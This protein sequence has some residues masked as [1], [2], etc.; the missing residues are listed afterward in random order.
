M[1]IMATTDNPAPEAGLGD[2]EDADKVGQNKAQRRIAGASGFLMFAVLLSRLLG[3]VREHVISTRFG[4]GVDTDIYTAAFTVPDLIFF[5][6]A[7]GGLSTAIIPTFTQYMNEGRKKEAWRIFKVVSLYTT[8][9]VGVLILIGEVFANTLIRHTNPGFTDEEVLRCVGL[10]RILLPAQICFFLG[11]LMMGVLQTRNN[12]RGQAYGPIIYNLGIIFGGV[13]LTHFMPKGGEIAGLCWGAV[14]GALLGNLALQWWF[15]KRMGGYWAPE[16]LREM[17]RD[18]GVKE[19]ALQ[20]WRM[21]LPI[22]LGVALPQVSALM[23][24]YYASYLDKGTMSALNRANQL[25]QV[26][27]G[28]FGQ[29]VSIAILPTLAAQFVKKDMAA[30]RRTTNFGLRFILFLTIPCSVLMIVLAVPIVQL[31]LQGGRYHTADSVKAATALSFYAIGIMAWSAQSLISR[32]FYSMK[33]TK[34]PVIVGTVVTFLIFIPLNPPLLAW[35]DYRGLALATSISATI[36]M[37]T[38][39]FLLR[40]RLKGIEGGKLLAS[41]LK[42]GFASAVMGTVCHYLYLKTPN[43]RD[44][45]AARQAADLGLVAPHTAHALLNAFQALLLCSAVGLG[46]YLA[47]ALLLRMDEFSPVRKIIRRFVPRRA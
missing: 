14:G 15:V 37:F 39:F 45:E 28:V 5:L 33:D 20:V 30:I 12:M 18:P 9:V 43:F 35:L 32:A 38:L 29:A 2:T 34:T 22:I 24:R 19:G 6:I 41:V 42:I 40:R 11:G 4:Q 36:N 26:P 23:N 31:A 21:M 27:L 10:T 16:S 13:V 1:P 47:F 46:I 3:L 44:V 25:M 7:G 17:L 8:M